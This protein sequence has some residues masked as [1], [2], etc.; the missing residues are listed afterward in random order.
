MKKIVFLTL[1]NVGL[2]AAV[3]PELEKALALSKEEADVSA[4]LEKQ[5]VDNL[6]KLEKIINEGVTLSESTG[7]LINNLPAGSRKKYTQHLNTLLESLSNSL[8][9]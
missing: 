1:I 6:E 7:D 3:D 4:E 2:F 5:V 8:K 9:Q